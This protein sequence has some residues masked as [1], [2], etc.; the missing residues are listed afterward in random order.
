MLSVISFPAWDAELFLR[1][2]GCHAAWLDPLMK[3]LSAIVLWIPLYALIAFYMIRKERWY[4][5][6][7]ITFWA[8][9]FGLADQLSVSLFKENF[10]RLRPC[11]EPELQNLIHS[12][13]SCGGK[14][15]FI[16][17]HAA[18]TFCLA[19]FTSLFFKRKFYT[20][21]IFLWAAAVAYSRIYVGKHY[22]LDVI[23]GAA[24]GILCGFSVFAIYRL[25][26]KLRIK[27]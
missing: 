9:A 16:S 6:L 11:H 14:Y 4:G 26:Y 7:T 21:A 19:M 27:N 22:P 3:G 12:L 1:L 8:L 5:L 25:I 18:N 17:N 23:C 20:L 10:Q 2:N 15:G 13:E 24:F